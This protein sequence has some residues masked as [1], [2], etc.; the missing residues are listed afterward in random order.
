MGNST[1]TTSAMGQQQ[2][3]RKHQRIRAMSVR[4]GKLMFRRSGKA[5]RSPR[6]KHAKFN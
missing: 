2:I 1:N 3:N 5:K 4:I 6:Q